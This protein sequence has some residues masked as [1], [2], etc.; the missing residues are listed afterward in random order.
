MA[1]RRVRPSKVLVGTQFSRRDFLKLSG[2]G[3]AGAALL[4]TAGCGSLF[5][6]RGVA[7]APEDRHPQHQPYGR[8]A[9][10]EL[11]DHDRRDLVQRPDQPYG[12]TLQARSRTRIPNRLW[13]RASRS[14]RTGSPTRSR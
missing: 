6:G 14:A 3:L 11:R 9:R 10:P 8:G 12:R 5:E 7:E 4:G 13:P 2:T 1:I